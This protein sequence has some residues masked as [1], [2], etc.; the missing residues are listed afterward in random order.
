MGEIRLVADVNEAQQGEELVHGV[1]AIVDPEVLE[2]L[3]K[4]GVE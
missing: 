1:V 4:H 3:R 2:A